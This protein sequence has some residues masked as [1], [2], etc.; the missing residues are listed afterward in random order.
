MGE[1]TIAVLSPD[2]LLACNMSLNL[3]N[4]KAFELGL[5]RRGHQHLLNE[6]ARIYGV[7]KKVKMTF[8]Y[9]TGVITAED[10]EPPS[11]P[12]PESPELEFYKEPVDE[13]VE[14]QHG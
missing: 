6:M 13:T 5:V 2:Q 14:E 1:K 10:P 4:D 11:D 3:I 9:K 12:P 8:D 7:D